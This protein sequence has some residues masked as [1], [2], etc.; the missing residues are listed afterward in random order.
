MTKDDEKRIRDQ[1]KGWHLEELDAMRKQIAERDERIREL[2]Q[3]PAVIERGLVNRAKELEQQ[4]QAAQDRLA[5]AEELMR[6]YS[7]ERARDYFAKH[8]NRGEG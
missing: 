3:Q 8:S 7:V 6:H 1:I 4:L 5:E 2:E